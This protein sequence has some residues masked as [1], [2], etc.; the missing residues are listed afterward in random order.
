MARA[1]NPITDL[2][3]I[4]DGAPHLLDHTSE[5]AARYSAFGRE[6]VDVHPIGGIQSHGFDPDNEAIVS[7]LGDWGTC[8]HL[9]F[10]VADDQKR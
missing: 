7:E 4:S 1:S 5:V 3:S 2:E 8:V 10:A 6:P 9:G